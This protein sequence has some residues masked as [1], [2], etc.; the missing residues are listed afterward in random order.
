[1]APER[2]AI[3]MAGS[4][5][6]VTHGE[7][8]ERSNRLARHLRQAG[9]RPGDHLAVFLENHPAYLEVIWAA[10]RSGLYLTTVNRYLTAGEAG[11]I[12]DNCDARALVTSAGLEAVARE[13]PGRAP[14]CAVR[15]MADG[16]ADGYASYEEAL[17]AAAP[18]PLPEEPLGELMPYSSGTTGQP[19]GIV[20]PL[21]GAP[22]S[23]GLPFVGLLAQLFGFDE[24]SVYLS[25]APMYHSAPLA[26]TIATTALGG[27][28]VMLERFDPSEALAAMAQH[29]VTHSQWVPTMF[30]RLLRLP[31]EERT[32]FDLSAHRVAIHAA[33]PCPREVK[34]QMFGWWGPILHEYYGGSELNGLTYVGPADWLSHPGTVGRPILGQVRICDESGRELPVGEVGLVYFELPAVPFAYYK[35]ETKTRSAQNP[36]HPTWTTLGDMGRIDEDLYLY[37]T[38]RASFM[39]ISGGVNIYPQEIED[40]LVLH[41]AVEDAAVIGV[42]SEEMGEEVKAVVQLR[43]GVEPRPALEKELLAYT[44]DR[45]AHYKCPR[46][47]DFVPELPRLPTGKLYKLALRER[48]WAGRETRIV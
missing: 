19:K 4:G 16:T 41:P 14:G 3:I 28:V 38:D 47:V 45:L 36:L 32:A 22:A 40:C 8:D 43:P 35:D 1:V 11:Y 33:A 31:V 29:G 37:L 30:T 21:S 26:F 46:S 5:L 17:A 44:R 12:V 39:I 34:E 15:L 18:Q 48:Y 10:L 23:A 24:R 6:V 27:T 9:L 13:L 2:P 7:L 20:R 25:T 42:P